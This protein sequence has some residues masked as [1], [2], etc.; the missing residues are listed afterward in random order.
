MT[1]LMTIDVEGDPDSRVYECTEQTRDFLRRLDISATVFV[2][3]DVVQN[4][5]EIVES[6]CQSDHEVGLHIHPARLNGGRDVCSNTRADWLTE[7]DRAEIDTLVTEALDVFEATLGVRPSVFRAGR[8]EY[9]DCLLSVLG[10]YGFTHDASLKPQRPTR[11]YRKH[12]VIETPLTV[13]WNRLL[14][15]VPTPWNFDAVP[16]HADAFLAR[17][18]TIPP[19][20]FATWRALASDSQYVIVSCHDY[21]L[22]SPTLRSRITAYAT[23]LANRTQSTTVGSTSL[24]LS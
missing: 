5:P 4:R 9:S 8:W 24:P 17:R 14:S 20:Y 3:P 2:T 12:S 6:W 19:F 7:Y 23:R 15:A 10:E 22:E 16:L 11:P 1:L 18:A 13:Y 21:D